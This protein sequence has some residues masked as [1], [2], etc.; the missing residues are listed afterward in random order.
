MFD[1]ESGNSIY[2]SGNGIL[3]IN[4][5]DYSKVNDD[6]IGSAGTSGSPLGTGS[7]TKY[8]PSASARSLA[9][10]S[11]DYFVAEAVS[12][13]RALI[14]VTASHLTYTD[15]SPVF[16]S[17]NV[18]GALDAVKTDYVQ[19]I[20]SNY[21][22]TF[23]HSA[24]T[25]SDTNTDNYH[26]F[27]NGF[28]T[29]SVVNSGPINF[30][31]TSNDHLLFYVQKE[32]K[33]VYARLTKNTTVS[34]TFSSGPLNINSYIYIYNNSKVYQSAITLYRIT[35]SEYA[36]LGSVSSL[37]TLSQTIPAGY[38]ISVFTN[39]ESGDFATNPSV[40]QKIDLYFESV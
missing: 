39:V 24:S 1:L 2:F 30:A 28:Y 20:N 26:Y 16:G 29:Q 25:L 37:N 3:T 22:V 5:F 36:A 7:I 12:Y 31:S 27:P 33:L 17:T 14:G 10:K 8:S 15:N 13:T 35:N 32:S 34:G 21:T 18:Q 9:F 19:K 11:S 40:A 38:Y 4:M 23:S 6:C